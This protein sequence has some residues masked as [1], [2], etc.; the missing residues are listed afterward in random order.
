M[1]TE[2]ID[3]WNPGAVPEPVPDPPGGDEGESTVATGAGIAGR[4]VLY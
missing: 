2:E 1:L 3:W 4:N